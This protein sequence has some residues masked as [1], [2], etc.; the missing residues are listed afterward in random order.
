MCVLAFLT[1]ILC[2]CGT[3]PSPKP[4]P[5]SVCVAPVTQQNVAI[6]GEWVASLEGY[7]NANIQP[8]V[9]GYLI[10]QS[11]REGSFV[12]KGDVLFEIDP[13]PFQAALDQANGQLAQS[14]GQL[15]QAQA[16]LGL[17]TINVNRDTPL[18]A[19]HAV[20]ISQLDTDR[21]TQKQD[22]ALIKT[23]QANIE[24]AQ[25]AV[26]TAQINLGFTEVRS[27][28]DGIAGIATTQIGNLVSPTTVLTSVSQVQP[29][30]VYFPISEQE[31]LSL[32]G[33]VRFTGQPDLLQPTSPVP[34][35]LTLANGEVYKHSGRI[36][37]ADRQVNQQTGT[38]TIVGA[39]SNP[40]NI[41]R[42]GQYGR[43]RAMTAT[44]KGALLI[45]QSAVS[46]LQGRYQVAIVDPHNRVTIRNVEPGERVGQL[47]VINA[48]LTSGERVISEGVS[49][50]KD[51][52]VVTPSCETAPAPQ[53]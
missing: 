13:R 50:V 4:S 29:V 9:S 8:E 16:Q 20:A 47:W 30:K 49:K 32:A 27:L 46:Q 52:Q 48:G 3:K 38:I 28:I 15:A 51:G 18:A 6:Y 36:L 14:R 33:R 37:F 34:L 5:P 7:T 44:R 41:L 11:Y 10:H 25:A 26:E 12:H 1:T 19:A 24:A 39:F 43:I 45:P 21:Q 35:Q 42:P 31:Y 23:D 17:A 53:T 40:G 22:E 2:A